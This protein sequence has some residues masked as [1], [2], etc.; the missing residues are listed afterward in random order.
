MG[1]WD[2]A[3]QA[4]TTAAAPETGG[5]SL[6]LPVLGQLGG[7]AISGGL[8]FLG[9][10]S[11]NAANTANAQAQRDWQERMDN[12]KYQRAVKDLMAAG[13]NPMMAFS[14]MSASTPSG[15]MPA[16]MQ[17]T[18]SGSARAAGEAVSRISENT[19]RSAQSELLRQQV[20]QS[21][22]ANAQMA[23]QIKEI[24]SKIGLN[25]AEVL[26]VL[27][28]IPQIKASARASNAS[29]ANAEAENASKSMWS[30]VYDIGGKVTG[31]IKGVAGDVYSGVSGSDLGKS[32]GSLYDYMTGKTSS[33]SKKGW[34]K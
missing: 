27:A 5:A 10:S 14:N 13:L 22:M 19:Q 16:P 6:L 7:S 4:V 34:F 11:A 18:L 2:E 23:A 33:I 1:I 15:A 12:T 17:S 20:E 28:T 3:V 21:K 9:T 30:N 8:D 26:R 24:D 25:N 32:L 29:A 31:A